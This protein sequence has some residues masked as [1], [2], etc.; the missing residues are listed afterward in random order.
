MT[1]N[2]INGNNGQLVSQIQSSNEEIIVLQAQSKIFEKW[3][4]GD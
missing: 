3:G 1:N 2:S 4:D